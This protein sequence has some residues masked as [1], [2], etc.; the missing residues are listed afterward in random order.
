MNAHNNLVTAEKPALAGIIEEVHSKGALVP[1][2]LTPP[3]Q[4]DN[5][6]PTRPNWMKSEDESQ[7]RGMAEAL[8]AEVKA[9]PADV[10]LLL[11]AQTLG[12]E[13]NRMMTPAVGLYEKKVAGVMKSNQEGN[14][15]DKTLLDIKMQMDLVNPAVLKT[16]PLSVRM[17]GIAMPFISRVP[18]GNEVIKM[19]YEVRESVMSTVKGLVENLRVEAD[20]LEANVED[21]AMI[22]RDLLRG[23]QFIERDIYVGQLVIQSLKEYIAAMPEGPE[24][25]NVQRFAA[26]LTTQVISLMGEENLNM[27]FFAGSQAIAQLTTGQ[28]QNIRGVSRVLVRAVLANLANAVAAEELLGSMR[29]TKMIGDAI[30]TTMRDTA[31]SLKQGGEEMTRMRSQ[32]LFDLGKLQESCSLYE[33]FYETQLQANQL[34]LEQGGK[35][36]R[37]LEGM[38]SRLRRRVESG[39][40]SMIA[41]G[42]Q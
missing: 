5:L 35:T 17:L 32:G 6:T 12:E 40:E 9:S 4:G 42:S 14:M 24:R 39:H 16:K 25:E 7:A 8:M 36:M 11:K 13:G 18:K 26:D 19:I 29:T 38:T 28:L 20:N 2:E 41:G 3:S 34:V 31:A 30:S 22:Y 23:Q 15:V 33:Q 10:R 27:Q 21:L 1:V 37:E